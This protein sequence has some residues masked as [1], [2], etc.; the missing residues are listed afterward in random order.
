MMES[1]SEDHDT[2]DTLAKS[3]DRI[4]LEN[5]EECYMLVASDESGPTAEAN[6]EN[7]EEPMQA[8]QRYDLYILRPRA[9]MGSNVEA[10]GN[11]MDVDGDLK[12]DV[13][14]STTDNTT[15]RTIGTSKHAAARSSVG[16]VEMS[17]SVPALPSPTSVHA[18]PKQE[19][20]VGRRTSLAALMDGPGSDENTNT[21]MSSHAAR[22]QGDDSFGGAD[23]TKTRNHHPSGMPT[24][25]LTTSE[26]LNDLANDREGDVKAKAKETALALS[27]VRARSR[28][29]TRYTRAKDLVLAVTCGTGAGAY[30]SVRA[31]LLYGKLGAERLQFV[32]GGVSV[33]NGGNL[34]AGVGVSLG[35]GGGKNGS[36]GGDANPS[37]VRVE[38]WRY[39]APFEVEAVAL[40][41]NPS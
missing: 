14:A 20:A 40:V 38:R 5:S 27:R 16:D 6:K 36:S 18:S 37:F 11:R 17:S 7:V 12:G 10:S 25:P 23:T 35:D 28:F 29:A 26:S 33:L 24:P 31:E 19:R 21:N 41:V 13:K 32:A 1:S 4:I 22:G 15:K 3:K 30:A 34:N 39:P 8:K 2:D 9:E